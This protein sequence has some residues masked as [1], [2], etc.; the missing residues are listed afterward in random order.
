LDENISYKRNTTLQNLE[1]GIGC[2]RK[3]V[4]SSSEEDIIYEGNL[5]PKLV[6]DKL[7]EKCVA[8]L[9]SGLRAS[10]PATEHNPLVQD[11]RF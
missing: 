2:E 4:L 5:S 7:Y 11:V 9:G 6:E 8:E 10:S 3:T 1:E